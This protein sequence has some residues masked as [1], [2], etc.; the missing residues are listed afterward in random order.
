MPQFPQL[1]EERFAPL[2]LSPWWD[3]EGEDTTSTL[4][5]DEPERTTLPDGVRLPKGVRDRQTD[6]MQE[7]QQ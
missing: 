4:H 7:Q 2:V 3:H 6:A 5:T 1:K